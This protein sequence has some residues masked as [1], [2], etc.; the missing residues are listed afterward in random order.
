MQVSQDFYFNADLFNAD[1]LYPVRNL[2][3][4]SQADSFWNIRLV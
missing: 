3:L 1:L 4:K 2:A